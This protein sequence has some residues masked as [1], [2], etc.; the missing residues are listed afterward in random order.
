M[1]NILQIKTCIH[2]MRKFNK[3]A[4][5]GI[6]KWGK[7]LIHDFSKIS[8]ITKCSSNGDPNNIKW[9]KKWLKTKKVG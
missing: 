9:L 5:I 2:I 1:I 3:I 6:G 4:V 8:H 7:N